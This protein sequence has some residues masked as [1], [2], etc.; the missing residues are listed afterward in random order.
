MSSDNDLRVVAL[1]LPG[2]SVRYMP[3]AI[4][5]DLAARL[6]DALS[7]QFVNESRK[8]VDGFKLGRK[9][10]VLV[11]DEQ[12]ASVIPAIWGDNVTVVVFSE[13][14]RALRDLVSRLVGGALFN[15][16][17]AN[18]YNT[19]NDSIQFHSDTEERGSVSCIASVSLGAARPFEFRRIPAGD[20]NNKQGESPGVVATLQLEHASLL[21]MGDGCQEL[22]Q[23]CLPRCKGLSAP[24]LNLTLRLFDAE[25]YAQK[26]GSDVTSAHA[27][28]AMLQ[29]PEA[30]RI[31]PQDGLH[32]ESW[33]YCYASG[34]P[35]SLYRGVSHE[36]AA[37]LFVPPFA[38]SLLAATRSSSAM[39]ACVVFLLCMLMCYG[40][41]SQYHRRRWNVQSERLMRRWDRAAI[42]FMTA[43]SYTPSAILLLPPMSC[44]ILMS[45][46]W[47]GVA[48]GCVYSALKPM[49][50]AKESRLGLALYVLVGGSL[51]PFIHQIYALLPVHIFVC[52]PIAW[53]C[54]GVGL[55]VYARRKPDPWPRTFGYHEV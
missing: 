4:P 8:C 34:E 35:K 52:I 11:E 2:A 31:A 27:D 1:D 45:L 33:T 53:A 30:P 22:Y 7:A 23:H 47:G 6:W 37:V 13:D 3:A 36:L 54:Y 42:Y 9:T 24:R 29:S 19:G 50:R 5:P 26:R 39:A 49:D 18:Y 20:N 55:G 15:I 14:V 38:Y 12:L 51:L 41:S 43:G 32:A 46:A 48:I 10:L 17:L 28:S 21:V 25:R 44:I 16:C 40:V